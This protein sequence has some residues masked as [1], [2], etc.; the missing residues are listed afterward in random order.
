MNPKNDDEIGY[1]YGLDLLND[2]VLELRVLISYE[3]WMQKKTYLFQTR[4]SFT[5]HS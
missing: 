1:E 4:S 2:L 5:F 3:K